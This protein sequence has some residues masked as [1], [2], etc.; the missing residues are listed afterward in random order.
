MEDGAAFCPNCGAANTQSQNGA[1]NSFQQ[2]AQQAFKKFNDTGDYTDQFDPADVAANKTISIL[3]YLGLLFLI[4]LLAAPQSQYARYHS[5]QGIVLCIA[6]IIVSV[7][8]AIVGWIPVIGWII[9]SVLG[10][11]VTVMMIIGIINAATGKAKDLPF[12]GKIRL[13]K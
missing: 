3:A 12:I 13:L 6:D 9:S 2:N 7:A 8:L 11:A 4:P 10:I 5:N 1:Q